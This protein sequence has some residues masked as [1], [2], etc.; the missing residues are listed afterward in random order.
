MHL[1]VPECH[2]PSYPQEAPSPS[3]SSASVHA[4][5]RE[6]APRGSAPGLSGWTDS[7]LLPLAEDPH[8]LL[9]ITSFLEDIASGRIDSASRARLLSCRL[10]PARKKDGGVRP[11][12]VSE[13]FLRAATALSLRLVPS[14]TLSHLLA[15][16]Q[17][18]LGSIGGTEAVIHRVQALLEK[19]PDHVLLSL[20]FA[21]GF[22]SMFRHVMLERLYALPELA[23]VWRIAD[24]CYSAPSP[25]HLYGR[26]GLVAS[27]VSQRGSR[28]GCV[29]GTLLFCLGLQPLLEEASRDLNNLTVS[30]YIDDIAAVGPMDQVD[31]FFRRLT[32]LVPEV[33]LSVS[34]SK[35]SLLWPPDMPAPDRV[36]GW[37][38]RHSIPLVCGSVPLLGSM[39]GLDSAS[40]QRFAADRVKSMEPLFRASVIR[41]H[42]TSG[43]PLASGVRAAQVQ[44]H[45]PHPAAPANL[46]SLWDL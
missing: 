44:F 14:G 34:P 3:F 39:V 40:R 43:F 29:L 32:T 4:Y 23:P 11:I 7:L 20:D 8:L 33:G 42:H 35:S 9:A 15:P 5:L 38:D 18:G 46:C 21:N 37:T 17:F 2:I 10:I 31:S 45:L 28:Q 19:Q 24:L 30:A 36:R 25:L 6:R 1:S 27:F 22:N 13:V 16:I 41:V 12:A 26:D